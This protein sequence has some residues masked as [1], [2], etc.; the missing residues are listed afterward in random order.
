[1]LASSTSLLQDNTVHNFTAKSK[2]HEIKVFEI[3]L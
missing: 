3:P 2:S 1:M